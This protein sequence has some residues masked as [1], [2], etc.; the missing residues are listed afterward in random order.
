MTTVQTSLVALLAYID[1]EIG[2]VQEHIRAHIQCHPDLQQQRK[3]LTSIPG[4]GDLTAAKL[5]AE[6]E[7]LSS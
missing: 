1:A 4:I 5:L 6:V 7:R 2:R 3:L